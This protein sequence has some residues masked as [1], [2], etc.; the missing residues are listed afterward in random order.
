MTNPAPGFTKHPNHSVVISP[1]AGRVTVQLGATQIAVSERAL[2]LEESRYAPAYYVPLDDIDQTLLTATDTYCPFKGHASYW[3]I[4][5]PDDTVEDA[6]WAYQSPY[7]ECLA[8]KDHA[9]F[10]GNKVEVTVEGT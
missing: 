5:T 9:A 6:L 7:D 1:F 8:L 2:Q 10:Y 3:T 4:T